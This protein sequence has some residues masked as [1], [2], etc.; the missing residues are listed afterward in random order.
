MPSFYTPQHSPDR[1]A[2][3]ED[4][5]Y[6]APVDELP[7]LTNSADMIAETALLHETLFTPSIDAGTM[8]DF[9]SHVRIG[10]F[11][12]DDWQ[13][14]AFAPQ[15]AGYFVDKF[16][17]SL[18]D[19]VDNPYYRT[20]WTVENNPD[21]QSSVWDTSTENPHLWFPDL[22]CEQAQ[23]ALFVEPWYEFRLTNPLFAPNDDYHTMMWSETTNELVESLGYFWPG[24][25]PPLAGVSVVTWDLSTYILN[26]SHIPPYRATGTI[27]AKVPMAPFYFSYADIEACGPDGDLGH[28]LALAVGNYAP[29]HKWPVR[30][31][32]GTIQDIDYTAKDGPNGTTYTRRYDVANLPQ[33]G[34]V[35]RLSKNYDMDRLTNQ[36][37]RAV[38]RTLQRHGMVVM[39][40]NT[41]FMGISTASD[42]RWPADGSRA[43]EGSPAS[44]LALTWGTN[45]P[46]TEFEAVDMSP[47][48]TGNP[49]SIEALKLQ[50]G[51]PT[52]Q[53]SFGIVPGNPAQIMAI[54]GD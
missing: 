31:G 30:G 5:F 22:R 25:G 45:M 16:P 12:A 46:I 48:Y 24:S 36:A 47:L 40:K 18:L 7:L 13:L 15:K 52:G 43:Y 19:Q 51:G 28:M 41:K 17:D 44:P 35:L 4:S 42:P 9:G 8:A 21:D 2:F 34:Q 1:S 33:A 20:N 53:Y 10:T 3:W 14:P 54:G 27:A 39:D 49:D 50:S 26:R 32:D 29:G 38:A 23:R 6:N 11:G 37:T